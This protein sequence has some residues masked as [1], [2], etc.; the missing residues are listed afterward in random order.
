MHVII[1][2][3]SHN[4]IRLL[5][6]GRQSA[7]FYI[8]KGMLLSF[9]N[10]FVSVSFSILRSTVL[11]KITYC[12]LVDSSTV[13]C[14]TNPFVILGVSGLFCRF[15][16]ILDYVASYSGSVLSACDLYTCFKVRMG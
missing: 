13:I 5:F 16:S 1:A 2:I 6:M 8:T 9:V 3:K 11:R 12:I 14:W 7:L 15:Y 4:I 10:V